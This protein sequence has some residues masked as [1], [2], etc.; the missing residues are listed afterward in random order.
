MKEV[1]E[2]GNTFPKQMKN[3]KKKRERLLLLEGTSYFSG[4]L[5]FLEV[6]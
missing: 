6:I 2:T 3:P 1:K 5:K 4:H